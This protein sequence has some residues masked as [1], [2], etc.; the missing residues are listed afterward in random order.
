M[1]PV[2]WESVVLNRVLAGV[3]V[4]AAV[5]VAQ[6]APVDVF[7][8]FETGPACDVAQTG[9]LSMALDVFG[10]FGSATNIGQD[11]SYNPPD[12]DPD[13]G[14]RGT[15]YE[16]KPFLCR[17]NGGRSSGAWLEYGAQRNRA[18]QADGDGTGL[19]SDYTVDGVRVSMAA[20]FE[21]DLLTQCWTFENTSDQPL[22]ELALIHYVD[23]DLFFVG[24]FSNDFA[25]SSVGVPRTIYEFDTG[26]DPQAPTTQLALF[27]TDPDD[28]YLTG[29]EVAEFS[30][31]RTRI[32]RTDN[33]CEPLRNGL[34]RSQGNNADGDGDRVTDAGYDVTLALR[35]DTGPLAP[36]EMSPAICY[37]LRWGYALACS[38]EDE[39]GV[40]VPEDNCPAVA[41]PGQADRDRDGVGD[42]CDLCPDDRD[43]D[44][45]DGDGDGLGDACDNCPAIPNPNQGDRDGDGAGDACDCEPGP[46]RCNGQDDDCDG[47]IDESPEGV[48]DPCATGAVGVCADG[49]RTCT[50]GVGG[51]AP[52]RMA[53][54][55][56]CDGLDNDCDGATDEALP[57]VG[58]PCETAEAGACAAGAW[59]C[60]PPEGLI[61]LSEAGPSVEVCDGLDN[62]CDGVTDNLPEVAAAPCVTGQPGGCALGAE[63]CLDGE[64]SCVPDAA[65]R[66][67]TCDGTD[68][69]C[70]GTIDEAMRNACGRCGALPEDGCDGVD[71][72]CDGVIDEDAACPGMGACVAGRC[73]DPCVNF[74]C[75][76]GLVCRDG[77]CVGP[78]DLVTCDAGERCD[79]ATGACVDPCADV[80]CRPGEVCADGEC[81]GEDDCA[82]TGC[83]AD[84]RCVAGACEPDPCAEVA[85]DADAFCRAGRCVDS[86]AAVACAAD[87]V[88]VDGACISAPCDGRCPDGAACVDGECVADPCDGVQCAMGEACIAGRCEGDPCADVTCPVGQRCEVQGGR[89]QCLFDDDPVELDGGVAP[90]PDAGFMPDASAVLPDSSVRPDTGAGGQDAGAAGADALPAGADGG[91]DG[92]CACDATRGEP[93]PLLA[94]LCLL[95]LV[96][97]RRG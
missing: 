88:C 21:C 56:Q 12:D 62:D 50:A 2:C 44:Q 81:G 3:G 86:C 11:A 38:D 43:A 20:S 4:W 35:F 79:P 23:G 77:V 67:E 1:G 5:S 85:C 9:R 58:A 73:V 52:V 51:C 84:E 59:V 18:V 94:L 87:E 90:A 97:R 45:A 17:T 42:A 10:S 40:C 25:G 36:G 28:S 89:A 31:S 46:E 13:R 78:C 27:G 8:R 34:T 22:D 69:D 82:F 95:G 91:G 48:G 30:E 53:E 60:A 66:D 39:D 72:D 93:A 54:A 24:N 96:R 80:D 76:G 19:T 7:Q 6:A 32:A 71:A 57:Q 74:E 65:P 14:A 64:L 41:N 63:Q 26:D 68:E 15:V 92:G 29:W 16:S 49:V 75:P 47:E 55:E 70:D 33:G 61:C 37:S 83:P